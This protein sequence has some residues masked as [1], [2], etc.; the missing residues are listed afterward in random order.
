MHLQLAAV[1]LSLTWRFWTSFTDSFTFLYTDKLT[2]YCIFD[3]TYLELN[4]YYPKSYKP[5]YNNTSKA[6]VFAHIVYLAIP[7][8]RISHVGAFV[9]FRISAAFSLEIPS[10]ISY[11]Q[12]E[13]PVADCRK[14]A[15]RSSRV[16]KADVR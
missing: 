1:L 14:G 12:F 13:I 3:I 4:H 6:L 10:R 7:F 8:K 5:N 15:R 9:A 16:V 2:F 11:L